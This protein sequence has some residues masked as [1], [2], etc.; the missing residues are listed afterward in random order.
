MIMTWNEYNKQ[1]KKLGDIINKGKFRPDMIIAIARGG[2]IPARY[3]SD[4]LHVKEMG[5][6]GIK[7]EDYERTRLDIYSAPSIPENCKKLLLVEDMLESGKSIKWANEYYLDLGYETM[8]ASLFIINRTIFVP[9]YYLKIIDQIKFP[10]E[11]INSS[12]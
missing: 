5:S 12:I 7:Y 10:W 2:W 8:T 1:I 3:L 9:N 6:I 4:L 11:S